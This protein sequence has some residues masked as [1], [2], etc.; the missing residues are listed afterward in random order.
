MA[1]FLILSLILFHL[2][3][4]FPIHRKKDNYNIS[5]LNHIDNI[6]LDQTKSD[7]LDFL[8]VSHQIRFCLLTNHIDKLKLVSPKPHWSLLQALILLRENTNKIIKNAMQCRNGPSCN[9]HKRP[10]RPLANQFQRAP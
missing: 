4:F 9:Q 8:E 7:V 2:I 6:N 5:N 10:E 3:F 1:V